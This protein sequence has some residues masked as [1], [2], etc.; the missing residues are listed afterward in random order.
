M[1]VI[2]HIG[3]PGGGQDGDHL[4]KRLVDRH[5]DRRGHVVEDQLDRPDGP[6]DGEKD[7]DATDF[8]M[9]EI[10][11]EAT[12]EQHGT[13]HEV[14]GAHQHEEHGDDVDGDAGIM[15]DAVR[16]DREPAGGDGRDGIVDG[17]EQRHPGQDI[18]DD[19]REDETAVKDEDGPGGTEGARGEPVRVPFRREELHA[20]IVGEDGR[21]DQDEADT[22]DKVE[23]RPVQ[24]DEV[25][26]RRDIRDRQTGRGETAHRFEGGLGNGITH[27]HERDGAERHCDDPEQKQ[28]HGTGVFAQ[29]ERALPAAAEQKNAAGQQSGCRRDQKGLC[30]MGLFRPEDEEKERS[31]KDDRQ[32]QAEKAERPHQSDAVHAYGSLWTHSVTPSKLSGRGPAGRERSGCRVCLRLTGRRYRRERPWRRSR[33]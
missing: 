26:H 5:Q 22:A 30:L 20:V 27:H 21:Q 29:D 11:F 18:Q 15:A 10:V 12:P 14:G 33:G 9:V 2:V 6:R 25:A 16:M 4:E 7:H 19:A 24:K 13:G 32:H 31:Q 3:E 17:V 8:D 1:Q 23:E 28:D